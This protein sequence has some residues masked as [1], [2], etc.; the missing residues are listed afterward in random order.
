MPAWKEKLSS[1]EIL[2]IINWITSLWP[3]EIYQI[4][5]EQIADQ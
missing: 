5:R 4:W 2:L 3:D 1:D